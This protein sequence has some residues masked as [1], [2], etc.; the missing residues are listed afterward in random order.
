[1]INTRHIRLAEQHAPDKV[2]T[3]NSEQLPPRPPQPQR[4][5]PA[6]STGCRKLAQVLAFPKV[7]ARFD[8]N[9]SGLRDTSPSG[10]DYS[11]ACQ[12]VA[13]GLEANGIEDVIAES[14]A[15]AS[16]PS[17]STTYLRVTSCDHHSVRGQLI[18]ISILCS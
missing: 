18:L 8:R 14:R 9:P 16:L 6:T 11:L 17:K 12:L 15:R 5:A 1:M 13:C 2:H 10:V 7:R 3:L 4:T